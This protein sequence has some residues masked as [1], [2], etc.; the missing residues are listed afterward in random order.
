[1]EKRLINPPS[2]FLVDEKVFPNLGLISLATSQNMEIIDFS[3]N[4][5]FEE[6]A[7]KIRG[8]W[9][10][11]YSTTPQFP[12]TYKIFEILKKNN[13]QSIFV[14]GGP[15]ASSM[16]SLTKDKNR[17][18]IE[19]FDFII[20]GEAEF[21]CETKSKIR[22]IDPIINLDEITIPNRKKVE[23]K[24][25]K[26]EIEGKPTTTI[27]T[28]RGCPFKCTFCSSR[29]V[30]MYKKVRQHSPKRILEEMDYLSSE[31]GYEAFMWYDDEIN[32]NPKRLE[33]IA[34]LLKKRDYIHRGFVRS[35]LIVRN[36]K[37]IDSLA[38]IGFVEL[39]FGVESG[40]NRILDIVEKGT[41]YDMNI[42]AHKM[43][44]KMGIKTKVFTILGLPDETY[45]DV[46]LTKKW[47][48]EANPDGFDVTILNPYPGSKIYNLARPS[49][50]IKGYEFEYDGLYF[51]KPDFSKEE[52]FFKGRLGEYNCFVRTDKLTSKDIINLRD[53]I[54]KELKKN[55]P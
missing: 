54:E 30:E 21:D 42:Q 12:M 35:D 39:C 31:F 55:M 25:Y 45:E 18:S 50:K 24:E 7:E 6:T 9:F 11:F 8:D 52:S 5:N 49:T 47:I 14:L 16:Y 37:S 36:P 28:Q 48:E 23:I 29:N 4:K 46:M 32:L 15:H 41:N 1:M 10:G 27:M 33:E 20:A 43:I 17:A 53:Q 3:G 44:K 19:E 26:Y 2:P 40:S 51:H 13:P 38:E 34:K 22:R